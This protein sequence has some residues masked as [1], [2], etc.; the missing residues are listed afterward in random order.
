M[1]PN[2]RRNRFGLL[3]LIG[4]IALALASPV[5]AQSV[6]SFYRGK[7]V[8]LIIPFYVGGG[9]DAYA[10]LIARFLPSYLPGTPTIVSRNMPGAGGLTAVNYLYNSAVKDGTIVE[11]PPDNIAL[12]QVMGEKN[13]QYDARKFSWI[14]RIATSVNVF[15]AWQTSPIKSFNDLLQRQAI[16]G[17]TQG[18]AA[19]IV[20]PQF[21]Q[22][23]LDAKIKLVTGF[24]GSSELD[25][26]L[27][28][29]EIELVIKPWQAVK[30]GNTAA[31]LRDGKITLLTQFSTGRHKD[32]P[33][34]PAILEFMQTQEQKQLMSVFLSP[35][36][37]GRSL[38]M[39]PGVPADRVAAFRKAF[40]EMIAGT[41]LRN[42]ANK[43]NIELDT[44]GGE[45]LQK[46]VDATFA[47]PSVTLEKGRQ[48]YFQH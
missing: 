25:R 42:E 40:H 44:L 26:A 32:L 13:I 37:V 27:E 11:A 28:R 2:K 34:L 48:F 47:L 16:E 20:Y 22:R 30:S 46:M 17:G 6:E 33:D 31:W 9:Y 39:P 18:H 35:G 29:G 3:G 4:L 1:P 14:G 5:R 8:E 36:E 10:R 43:L 38:I 19:S 21:L 24:P 23:F 15:Y 41:A 45:Q 12:G 7:T